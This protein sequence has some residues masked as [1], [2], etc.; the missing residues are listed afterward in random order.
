MCRCG[1][2]ES[3]NDDLLLVDTRRSKKKLEGDGRKAAQLS[4]TSN[5]SSSNS[6]VSKRSS[7]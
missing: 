5:R 6:N 3:D 2:G 7:R 4:S 1:F